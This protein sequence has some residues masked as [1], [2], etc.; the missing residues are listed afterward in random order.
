MTN[1]SRLS[2]LPKWK[3]GDY[4]G[5]YQAQQIRQEERG[6]KVMLEFLQTGKA[7]YI[8][9]AVCLM[10]MI[11][12]LAA[13]NLYKG[14]IKET[15]NMMLTKNKW[16]RE[17]R[18]RAEDT[19]RLNQGVANT[20]VFV[21]KQIYEARLGMFTPDGWSAFSNQMTALCFLLGGG[22]A[23]WA[24]WYRCDSYYIVLYSSMG[25]LAGVFNI[26]VDYGAGLADKRRRLTVA[27][28][29]YLE[30]VLWKRLGR[31]RL[32]EMEEAKDGLG[33]K[34]PAPS[35][36]APVRLL[37]GRKREEG[38]VAGK[39]LTPASRG[40]QEGNVLASRSGQVANG[41]RGR[42]QAEE[43]GEKGPGDEALSQ[44]RKSLEQA[45][46]GRSGQGTKLEKAAAKGGVELSAG[47]NWMKDL[48]PEEIK[49][50]GEIIREYLG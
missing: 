14:L 7:V 5:F 50:L 4:N 12:K 34:Q 22:A 39:G 3:S 16:L 48:K 44:L 23:F 46:A 19:Y 35:K 30:N 18:Q 47:E 32:P 26:I 33:G 2:A 42:S 38:A 27:I 37:R 9:A 1:D 24:Y 40:G 21:E 28:Q 20:R 10:G 49:V 8:L 15:S 25:V 6:A 13:R 31:D 45:A 29:D 41:K 43:E 17:L 11:S 36:E